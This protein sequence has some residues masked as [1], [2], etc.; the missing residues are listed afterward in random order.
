MTHDPHAKALI[1]SI[2]HARKHY[3]DLLQPYRDRFVGIPA[4]K[5]V[6]TKKDVENLQ[7]LL[8]QAHQSAEAIWADLEEIQNSIGSFGLRNPVWHDAAKDT[9]SYMKKKAV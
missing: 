2:K 8:K 3:D 4:G 7:K 1:Q 9:L 5:E 6:P